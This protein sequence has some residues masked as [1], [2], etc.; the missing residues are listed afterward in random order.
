LLLSGARDGLPSLERVEEAWEEDARKC[1]LEKS[2]RERLAA[3]WL[4]SHPRR[5]C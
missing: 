1:R 4:A 5:L 2:R 3:D